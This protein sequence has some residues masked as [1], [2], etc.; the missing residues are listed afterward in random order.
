MSGRIGDRAD[1][2]RGAARRAANLTRQLLTF[3]RRQVM[4]PF[5][6]DP[7]ETLLGMTRLLQRV[8]GEDVTLHTRF[9]DPLP[10]IHADPGMLEQV[11]MNLAS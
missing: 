3:S 9:A 4:Q 10:H 7:R 5:E 8:L 2:R 6:L 11:L 1:D